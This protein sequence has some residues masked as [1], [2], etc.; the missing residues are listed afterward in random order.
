MHSGHWRDD[1]SESWSRSPLTSQTIV[2]TVFEVSVAMHSTICRIWK[3][4]IC[5]WTQSTRFTRMHSRFGG[6]P[7]S[8][9][10]SIWPATTSPMV[11]SKWDHSRRHNDLFDWS[12][13]GKPRVIPS[14][15]I[16][17]NEY[18]GHCWMRMLTM[19]LPC[20]PRSIHLVAI[21]YNVI[22][23]LDGSSTSMAKFVPASRM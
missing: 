21:G 12:W 8:Y 22:A 10:R 13:V 14:F 16:S 1:S 7:P 2:S 5:R 15:D 18:S 11:A 19:R 23:N 3:K 6:N 20:T 17:K 4:L 9:W